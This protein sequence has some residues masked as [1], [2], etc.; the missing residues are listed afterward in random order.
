MRK[1]TCSQCNGTGIEPEMDGVVAISGFCRC[2]GKG[3]W[4][5]DD[6]GFEII[7]EVDLHGDWVKL[8][9]KKLEGTGGT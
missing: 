1:V 3:F 5:E 6:A 8:P 4:Y 7:P 9:L 2:G